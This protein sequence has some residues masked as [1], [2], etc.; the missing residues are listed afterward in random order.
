MDMEADIY[1]H[2]GFFKED[3]K[4]RWVIDP[5]LAPHIRANVT[6]ITYEDNRLGHLDTGMSVCTMGT[7]SGVGT[8]QRSNT[9]T[10][11]KTNGSA[12]LVDA[13]EGIQRQFLNSRF[14]VRDIRKIFSKQ[15][16]LRRYC[17]HS[18][19]KVTHMH[20]DH[21]FGLPGLLLYLQLIGFGASEKRDLD[22]YGPPGIYNYIVSA[23]TLSGTELK[24]IRIRVHELHGGTQR[25][26]RLAAN[27]KTYGDFHQKGVTRRTIPQ[28]DDG[29]WTLEEPVE[30]TTPEL[31]IQNSSTPNGLSIKA[32]EVHHVPQLQCFGYT[33]EE[34]QTL[35]GTLDV[36]K[37]QRLG[38]TSSDGYKVLKSGFTVKSDDGTI[39]IEPKQVLKGP[40]PIPR[41]VT[42][43]GDCCMVP[44]VMEKLSWKSD[45]LVH[46]ATQS[47]LDKGTK[48]E[49]GGHSSAAEAGTFARKVRAKAL[50][51]NH[52][53]SR[54]AQR[55]NLLALA[56]EAVKRTDHRTRV[57]PSFDHL[58]I[59]IPRNG[60]HFKHQMQQEQEEGRDPK[61][62]W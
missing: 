3:P 40:K 27:R 41:K 14:N 32:A 39:D 53:P 58:E 46:E 12:Y 60:F 61:L 44:P 20:G 45:V 51:L 16:V 21:I 8:L 62:G 29:T 26:M 6:K 47:I 22:I 13:G 24:R 54:T 19:V 17:S 28:N 43:L 15:I 9:A 33:F 56:R 52:L 30:I 55:E 18:C 4:S 35:P 7:G 37:A 57:Q 49:G 34:P 23:V 50:I 5:V 25:S 11:I 48:V 2:D 31:A 36:E 38:C 10:V 42:I 59:L 1:T